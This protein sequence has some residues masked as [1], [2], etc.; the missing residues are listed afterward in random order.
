MAD[1]SI[2]VN[3]EEVDGDTL[4]IKTTQSVLEA[5]KLYNQC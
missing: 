2:V 4:P 3:K 5:L 1:L